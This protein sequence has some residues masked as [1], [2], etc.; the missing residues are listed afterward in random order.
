M[1]ETTTA[2]ARTDANQRLN[3]LA[4]F[5]IPSFSGVQ[6]DGNY[7]FEPTISTPAEFITSADYSTFTL[8][9]P[10]LNYGFKSYG[11][12]RSLI[13]Q[14]VDDAF[15]GGI[16]IHI[17]ELEDEDVKELQ[18]RMEDE[19]DLETAKSTFCWTRLFGGAGTIT[20]TDQDP[21]T[22]LDMDKLFGKMLRFLSADRWELIL[23]GMT[24]NAPGSEEDN[25]LEQARAMYGYTSNGEFNYYGVPLHG[26]RVIKVIGQEAPSL[27]RPRLQGWGLSVLEQC[28][29]SIQ[30]YIKFQ[31]LLFALVD[32]AKVDIYKLMDFAQQLSS[33][34][35]TAQ[36]KLR[37]GLQN[38][39]KNYQ[40]AIIIDKEDEYEQ[41]QIA[42]S[43]LADIMVEFRINLCADLKIPY[44]KL[45]GM[46]STGFASGEDSMENYNSMVEVEV[47]SKAR[48]LVRKIIELRCYQLWGYCPKFTFEFRPLRELSGVEEEQVRTSTQNRIM[49]LRTADQ[50]TGMEA[51]TLLHRE[52]LIQ[53]DTEVGQGLREPEP[54]ADQAAAAAEA[55]AA[56]GGGGIQ[57]DQNGHFAPSGGAA[58]KAGPKK[59]DKQNASG[60]LRLRSILERRA[61]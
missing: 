22:P 5:A 23:S 35:G 34:E 25:K 11:L 61:A 55:G 56:A 15:K 1:N 37:V 27:I 54:G 59:P 58:R 21:S 20:V 52:G 30:T 60:L 4:E 26:S 31:N 39:I 48:K 24:V 45:F 19:G 49:Q 42:F 18:E 12:V 9:R 2:L 8:N 13:S 38:A 33:D 41:K 17:P 16:T 29:R 6:G 28:M 53:I 3:S 7:G 36:T 32:E 40:N 47:R 43:G 10:A 14:P 46:S 44:N 51:D 57:R 50:I